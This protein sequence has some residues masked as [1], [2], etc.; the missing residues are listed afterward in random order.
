M[1]M[2]T[3]P[4]PESEK[5][6]R[7]IVKTSTQKLCVMALGIALFVVLSLCLQ[8]PV[9]ENYYLCLGYVAMAVYCCSFGAVSG[10]VVGVLGVVLYCLVISGLRGLPGWA[11]GNLVI[12]VVL[13]LVFPRTR[14]MKN[15]G[16]A[17]AVN[18]AAIL[19]SVTA[20]ILCL[21]SLL[22]SILYLQPV[23]VRIGKNFTAWVADL[24]VLLLSLPVCMVLDGL[25]RRKFPRLFT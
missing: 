24:A 18:A 25:L 13:G 6:R 9:F 12:G 15:R 23:A 14:K 11:L 10:T 16:L 17:A 20:G 4:A 1:R 19:V 8:V 21:K 3:G 2:G 7:A 5:E 22:E